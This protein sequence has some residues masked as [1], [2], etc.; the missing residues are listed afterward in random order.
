MT[1]SGLLRAQP[2]AGPAPSFSRR[3]AR[4]LP[5]EHW[6]FRVDADGLAL[7]GVGVVG[8]SRRLDRPFYLFS[9]ARLRANARRA[10]AA[11][12]DRLRGG[13]LL[14]SLKANPHPRVLEILREE[15]LGAE[16]VCGR[17]LRAAAQAEFEAART[18]ID[19]PGKSDA[20][21]RAAVRA[22][23]LIHVDSASEASALARIAAAEGRCARAGLRLNL[24]LFDARAAQT[25]RLGARGVA[26]G[27]DPSGAGFRE[28][29]GVLRGSPAVRIESLSAHIGTGV[30]SAEPYRMLAR[31]LAAIRRSLRAE[32]IDVTT[33][34]LGGGFAVPSEVRY[35]EAAFD[36]LAA[37][38]PVAVPR[39][40]EV[41]DFA[42]VLSAIDAELGPDPP[43]RVVL[44]PGRL[45]VSDA[46]HLVARVVRLKEEAG[47]RY[48]VL[49]AS[50]VQNA[51]FVGRGWHEMIH[52]A[53]PEAPDEGP[54]SVVGPLPAGFDVF[55][56]ARP[57]PR[58]AEGDALVVCDV[59]AYNLS[60]Q[61][62]W[63]F[64]PAPV[65]S[66]ADGHVL[67]H[68]DARAGWDG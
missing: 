28:A 25:V 17:E 41:A 36:T 39:P 2:E 13:D 21:L 22:G 10:R 14:Y 57:L 18:V 67:V 59:G 56:H 54:Y 64:D 46:F 33:L 47:V 11:A 30:G 49:E 40:E 24:D 50:R 12:A 7:D 66:V 68:E 51:L 63:S 19:G 43:V 42:D 9:E 20:D 15:G 16:T 27:L 62:R 26:F 45:L 58:I 1:P 60:A 55:A 32:G 23:A 53:R 38:R 8:L 37:G 3:R 52:A 44:E 5:L 61:S 29:L 34:D 4:R 31:Q 65:V 35:P 6:G 48:A